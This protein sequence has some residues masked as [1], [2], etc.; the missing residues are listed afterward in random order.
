MISLIHFI[1]ATR[2]L[3]ETEKTVLMLGGETEAPPM[4]LAQRDIIKLEVDYYKLETIRLCYYLI[5]L[6][7][8]TIGLYNLF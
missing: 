6:A 5:A 4:V 3:K 2:R 7:F 1:S 8:F